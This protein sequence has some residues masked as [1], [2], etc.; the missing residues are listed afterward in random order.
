MKPKEFRKFKIYKLY[1][2]QHMSHKQISELM[3]I[4]V[5]T[6][7][8]DIH[9]IPD[10]YKEQS[11]ITKLADK[12]KGL[13]F[14]CGDSHVVGACDK[15][16]WGIIKEPLDM[17]GNPTTLFDYELEIINAIETHH[18]VSLI[19]SR[20]IGATQLMVIYFLYRIFAKQDKGNYF[21]IC[22]NDMEASKGIMRRLRVIL[23]KHDIYTDDRETVLN[24]PQL[25]ARIQCYPSR[26]A[27]LR[28]WDRVQIAFADEVDSLENSQDIRSVLEAYRVKSGADLV[29]CSTPGRLSSTMHRIMKEPVDKCFYHRMSIDYTR[30]LGKLLDEKTIAGLKESS[31]SFE[32][33]FM[34]KFGFTKQGNMLSSK[35]LDDAIARPYSI[36]ETTANANSPKSMGIDYGQTGTGGLGGGMGCVVTAWEDGIVKVLEAR[37]WTNAEYNEVLEDIRIMVQTY[38]PVKIYTD[39][40]AV[41]FCRSIKLIPEIN[42]DPNYQQQI[43]MY[44]EMKGVDWT[45]NMRVIPVNWTKHQVSMINNLQ[46]LFNQNAI[47][48]SPTL[49]KLVT[50]LRTA[51]TEN[52]RLVKDL[53]QF[54]DLTDSLFLAAM[55]Y[56]VSKN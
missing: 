6:V 53:S 50:A 15:C 29:L 14:F 1:T 51:V 22:G 18:A 13:P 56:E 25:E 27:S 5:G 40:S 23:S 30:S 46:M 4:S 48:V 28:S 34:C 19:K 12:C 39:G 43:K 45:N 16:F 9:N 2:E 54:N 33:E 3:G 7:N 52:M 49:H 17:H 47:A 31:P 11:D 55:E 36:E 32:S 8:N 41:S 35:A 38:D 20:S 26:V 42:E 10:S 24:F 37:L 44:N 21:I